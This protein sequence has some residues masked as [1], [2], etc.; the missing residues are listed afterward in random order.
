VYFVVRHRRRFRR[1][2]SV[3][4]AL[5]RMLLACG[6]FDCPFSNNAPQPPS[7]QR[8]AAEQFRLHL[9]GRRQG[10]RQVRAVCGG[11]AYHFDCATGAN[12]SSL[13]L[14]VDRSLVLEGSVL[15]LGSRRRSLGA[16]P[17]V[18]AAAGVSAMVSLW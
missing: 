5:Q 10:H 1:K 9:L 6:S 2:G 3:Q 17:F 7:E 15:W 12:G 8:C 4:S 18:H 14:T 16:R 11:H 13:T